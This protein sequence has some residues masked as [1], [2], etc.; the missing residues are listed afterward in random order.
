MLL[1]ALIAAGIYVFVILPPKFDAEANLVTNEPL[2]DIS[3][4]A[5]AL[6][7]QLF[8]GDM[9]SDTLLWKRELDAAVDYGHMDL[10]RLQAGNVAL[11][12]FSSVTKTPKG[13]N[14]DS[15]SADSDNIPLLAIAQLQP[16]RT[17]QF[18]QALC[19]RPAH[20]RLHP[21]F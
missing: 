18:G 16:M 8:I 14:Y 7:R 9:H 11:Q 4:E 13:Q 21:F 10:P 6:H 20:V 15:N 17:C 2:L 1:F 5:K 19:K 3:D 12:I